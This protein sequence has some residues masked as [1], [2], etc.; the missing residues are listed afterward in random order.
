ML[1]NRYRA[2][3]GEERSVSN[4][5]AMLS[6]HGHAVDP[7][8]ALQRRPGSRSGRPGADPR[9]RRSRGGL[10]RG[11]AVRRRSGPRPQRPPPVRLARTRGRGSGRRRR[12]AAPAQPP[13]V[14]RGRDRVPR[15]APVLRM[16]RAQHAC[17]SG[18][19]MSRRLRRVGHLRGRPQPCPA[20]AAGT[21]RSLHHRQ[22]VHG[23]KAD[24]QRAP[25]PLDRRAAELHP[26]RRPRRPIG[27]GRR[28][29]RSGERKARAGEGLRYGDRRRAR[30]QRPARD[31]R[32]RSR[33]PSSG[34][35]GRRRRRPTART[36]RARAARRVASRRPRSSSC[37]PGATTPA[38]TRPPR[39]WP[40]GC[41]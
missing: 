23:G 37:R 26:G 34:G 17:R 22:P 30:S 35:A 11:S 4:L 14:L 24:G 12:G 13:V 28:R 29:L 40:T 1:H 21:R 2:T 27:R 18:A 41:P 15:R 20:T 10:G 33:R 39:R 16:P 19:P 32:G 38:R 7:A 6:R 3:G 8:G 25:R 36:G 5:V 9:R 31:R